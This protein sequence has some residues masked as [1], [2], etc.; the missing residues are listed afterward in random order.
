MRCRDADLF[1][2]EDA[3]N[4]SEDGVE[5]DWG[6]DGRDEEGEDMVVVVDVVCREECV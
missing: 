3:S 5:Y 6:Y 1:E 2:E 4:D